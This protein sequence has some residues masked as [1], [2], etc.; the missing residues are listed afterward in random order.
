MLFTSLL[1]YIIAL[2]IHSKYLTPIL[3][4]RIATLI[5]VYSG[6]LSF[7]ALYFQSLGSGIGI[8]SG[9]FSVTTLTQIFDTF[10]FII[11]SLILVAWPSTNL[12]SKNFRVKITNAAEYSLI[13]IFSTFGASLLVSSADLISLYLSIELQSFGVYILSTLFKDSFSS[14]IAGLKYFLL[15]AQRIRTSLDLCRQLSNSGDTLK[16]MIPNY[17]W[18]AISGWT[19]HSCTVI[20]HKMKET[21]IGY[22][23]SK[24]I[25]KKKIK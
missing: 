2:A 5:F 12:T 1:I 7:N 16:L 3:F 4:N 17:S 20:S 6:A 11:A 21:E 8:Y 10:I 19:N 9:Y 24:S 15:G 25:K 22:R 14:S 13:V 23:G 18:K